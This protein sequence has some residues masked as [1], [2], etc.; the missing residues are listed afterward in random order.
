VIEND[1]N[2]QPEDRNS[3]NDENIVLKLERIVDNLELQNIELIKRLE[4][5]E[6]TNNKPFVHRI[7]YELWLFINPLV[8]ATIPAVFT[9]IIELIIANWSIANDRWSIETLTKSTSWT[10]PIAVGFVSLIVNFGNNI[11]KTVQENLDMNL[12]QVLDA[13]RKADEAIRNLEI[14]AEFAKRDA[15]N[16][17]AEAKRDAEFKEMF[18][19]L[20]AQSNR[21]I[22]VETKQTIKN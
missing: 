14:K 8:L 20:A 21:L 15:D 18:A 10:I 9:F 11:Y 1:Q 13:K 12:V 6:G 7:S 17:A 16:K 19:N 5:I 22:V 4:I 2:V 3:K